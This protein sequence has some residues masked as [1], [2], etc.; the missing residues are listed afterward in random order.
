M[1]NMAVTQEQKEVTGLLT[2]PNGMKIHERLS[3]TL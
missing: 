2:V 3:V 1:L